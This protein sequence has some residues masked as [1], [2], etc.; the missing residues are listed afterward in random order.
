MPGSRSPK[1]P[2]RKR[3]ASPQVASKKLTE[4]ELR[5]LLVRGQ[6][7][8]DQ[9]HKRFKDSVSVEDYEVKLRLR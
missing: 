2:A 8:R 7:L 6:E 5:S 4:A 1:M 3:A 9:I